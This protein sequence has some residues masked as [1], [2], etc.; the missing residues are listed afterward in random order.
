MVYP[1]R[2]NSYAYDA[3]GRLT[4]MVDSVGNA[5]YTCKYSYTSGGFIESEDGPW[6][7]DTVTYRWK[8]GLPIG[9]SPLQPNAWPW[10]QGYGYD[11]AE[12]LARVSSPA[13]TFSYSYQGGG[14]LVTN[15]ALPNGAAIVNAFDGV[16]RL[17]GTWLRNGAG[18]ILNSHTYNVDP[19]HRRIRQARWDG[20]YVNYAYDNLGALKTAFGYE[21]NGAA[22]LHEQLGYAYD[23]AGNLNYRTNNGLVQRFEVNN[24]NALA[25]VTRR[26]TLTVAGTTGSAA[27]EVTV[28]GIPANRY[29][30]WTFALAGFPLAD[31]D[32][33]YTVIAQDR[34]G[35]K[36]R[37]SITVN[38]PAMVR[39]T[40]DRNGNLISDGSRNFDYDDENQLQGGQSHRSVG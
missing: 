40:Y 16:G 30:D 3:L 22:R 13:G 4:N 9:L 20:S 33:V 7:D 17:T 23:A 6:P 14:N 12:R 32:N 39:F 18:T 31:G 2:T 38:L 34:Y 24:L 21:R 27:T 10:T 19:A 35:R 36:D 11:A 1:S 25:D 8:N 26:G 15:L 28:N 29:N 5:R 37:N